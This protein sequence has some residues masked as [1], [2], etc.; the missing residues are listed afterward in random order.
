M[1]RI[2]FKSPNNLE[3]LKTSMEKQDAVKA[4]CNSKGIEYWEDVCVGNTGVIIP[5]Y[6]PKYRIAVRVGD[7]HQWYDAVKRCTHPIFIRDDNTVEFVIEKLRNT[8]KKHQKFMK[9]RKSPKTSYQLK[10]VKKSADRF[11]EFFSSL[12]PKKK[13][14]LK[15]TK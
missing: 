4:Y 11:K 8:I 7:S 6:L 1:K 12:R 2:D 9:H 5:L 3:A 15:K 14:V 10:I 13:Y